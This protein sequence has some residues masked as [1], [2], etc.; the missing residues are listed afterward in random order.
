MC[1][2]FARGF[3]FLDAI[4]R[5]IRHPNG[6]WKE[7]DSH[8]FD[9]KLSFLQK[10]W[11]QLQLSP[12]PKFHALSHHIKEQIIYYSGTGDF[13]EDFVEKS[14]HDG[15]K[16]EY[17]SKGLHNMVKK[18]QMHCI[19]ECNKSLPSVI[20]RQELIKTS[21]KRKLKHDQTASKKVIK[22]DKEQVKYD[23]ACIDQLSDG[24]DI[25][26]NPRDLNKND[27]FKY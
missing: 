17:R 25:I 24:N 12:T 13:S 14:H 20:E 6:Q 3:I 16:D 2:V 23:R 1:N 10:F 27:F 4:L 8:D 18:A 21:T 15:N 11:K 5:K 19:W 9:I 22:L 26:L 7:T